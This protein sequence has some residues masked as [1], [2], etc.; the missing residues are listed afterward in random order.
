MGGL[1][2]IG[3]VCLSFIAVLVLQLPIAAGSPVE[4]LAKRAPDNTIAFMATSGG[5]ALKGDFNRSILGQ[6]WNDPNTQTFAATLWTQGRAA[7][8]RQGDANAPKDVNM[9]LEYA[10][11]VGRRPVLIGAAQAQVKE[12]PPACF[13]AIIDAGDSKT[14]L[15]DAVTRLESRA[16]KGMFVDVERASLKMRAL[17]DDDGVPLY[18]GWVGNYFVIAANDAQDVAIKYVI[19]PRAS[20]PDYFKKVP[21]TDDA[22]MLRCDFQKIGQIVGPFIAEE[23]DGDIDPNNIRKALTQLGLDKIGGLTAR[24]GF[25][26]QEMISED[27]LEVPEPRTGLLAAFKPVDLGLMGFVDANAVE[28]SVVNCDLAAAYDTVLGTVKAVSQEETYAEIQKALTGLQ[29]EIKLDIRKDLLG[30]MAGPVVFYSLPA[31]K[32]IEAPM[33]GF[34]V[35]AKLKDAARFEK[36]MVSLGRY[37]SGKSEG[38]FLVSDQNDAGRVT[39]IWSIP[40]LALLQMMPTWSVVG[41][42]FVL[43]SSSALHQKECRYV[44]P[45][46][47]RPASLLDRDSYKKIAARLPKNLVSFAYVDSQAQFSATMTGIQQ[48]WP[49][50]TMMAAK[51]GVMLPFMLPNLD[52]VVRKMQPGCQYCYFD[53]DGLHERYEGEGVEASLGAVAGGAIVAGVAL[54]ALARTRDQARRISS[55]SNLKQIGMALM[56][57]ADANQSRMPQSLDDLKQY[58]VD[59]KRLS[60]PLK[61]KNFDGP[62][63]IYISGQT[64]STPPTSILVYENPGFRE[65]GVNVLYLDCHVQS[66]RPEQFR[67]EL[68]ETCKRLGKQTPKVRFKGETE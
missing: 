27:F 11:L 63:Y 58:G 48:L 55:M 24:M 57:S 61:P 29:S 38:A 66:V 14:Q 42:N 35:V 41:D 54:P 28:A 20:T 34:A 26:G 51:E 44:A 12:G 67:K 22:M 37:V 15:T 36:T 4:E 45:N 2:K 5:D 39:H 46:A 68:A 17:K 30:S 33:G 43:G 13:F 18:W 50:A 10:S 25:A 6:L 7:L 23:S 32:M 8:A 64:T 62:S 9:V 56:M 21:G 49:L 59:S 65:D 3:T 19:K 40:T 31:G 52:R 53:A 47:Q 1:Q 16:G 60:S